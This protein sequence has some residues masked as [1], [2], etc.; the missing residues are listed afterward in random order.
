MNVSVYLNT[1]YFN[2]VLLKK[3][4]YIMC[5]LF[6]NG[7][8]WR[9]IFIVFTQL[10]CMIDPQCEASEKHYLESTFTLLLSS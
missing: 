5:M 2:G 9:C 7:W 4:P 6:T 10:V 1:R 8:W 3:Q